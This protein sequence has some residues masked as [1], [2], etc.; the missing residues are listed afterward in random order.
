M[1][2]FEYDDYKPVVISIVIIL[3]V[4]MNCLVIVVIVRNPAL[5]Q[6]RTTL[7]VCS[8][9]V[10]DL[11]SGCTAMPIGAA[12][13]SSATQTVRMSTRYLPEIQMFCYWWFGFNSMYSL[14]WVALSKMFTIWKP[15][16][17]EKLLTRRRCYAIIVF[18]WVIGA[19]L[20][21]AKFSINVTWNTSVCSFRIPADDKQASKLILSTYVVSLIIPEVALIVAT[22]MMFVIVLR[23]HRQICAQI[24]SIGGQGA[25]ENTGLVTVQTIRSAKNIIIICVVSIALSAPLFAFAVLR[26]AIK[27]YQVSQRYRFI[28]VWLYN[29]NTFMNGLL[30]LVLYR[31]VR[32]KIVHIFVDMREFLR[33]D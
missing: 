32:N 6:D 25:T 3:N 7:F 12:L 13:C 9:C 16:R 22:A 18:N 27:D 5:R 28:D 11:A 26:H 19:A 33:R 17:Y 21:A 8:L 23:A 2:D 4:V 14:S 24:R 1:D 30:Y 10:S 29:S 15:L 31:S 20:A